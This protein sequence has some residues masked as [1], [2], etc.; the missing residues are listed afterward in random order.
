MMEK[1]EK[2]EKS[3]TSYFAYYACCSCYYT[4]SF[5]FLFEVWSI[6]TK[7]LSPSSCMLAEYNA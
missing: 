5:I 6:I 2:K 1:K 7:A 4:D 3:F